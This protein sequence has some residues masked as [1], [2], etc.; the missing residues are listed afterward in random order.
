MVMAHIHLQMNLWDSKGNNLIG[1]YVVKL[2][3]CCVSDFH[4]VVGIGGG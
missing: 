1:F 3:H 4:L 2:D